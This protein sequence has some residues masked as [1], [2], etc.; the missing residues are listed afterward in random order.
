VRPARM[1]DEEKPQRLAFTFPT[2]EQARRFADETLISF[3]YLGCI[4]S[5]PADGETDQAPHDAAGAD[6]EA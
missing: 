6:S 3:E 1:T 4:I 2:H 5:R